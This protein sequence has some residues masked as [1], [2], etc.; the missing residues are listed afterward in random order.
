MGHVSR[1]VSLQDLFAFVSR[2]KIK[3]GGLQHRGREQGSH[4]RGYFCCHCTEDNKEFAHP[5]QEG[6]PLCFGNGLFHRHRGF[7]L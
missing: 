1:K 3:R 4:F 2:N 7:F 6:G 5:F